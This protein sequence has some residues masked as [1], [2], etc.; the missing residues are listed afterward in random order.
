M[1]IMNDV[2]V[3]TCA[4]NVA[5]VA[6]YFTTLAAA[7]HDAIA[8]RSPP[9]HAD[10]DKSLQWCNNINDLLLLVNSCGIVSECL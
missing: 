10:L 3:R 9:V 7:Q 6:R 1:R 2:G 8:R 5:I 4:W